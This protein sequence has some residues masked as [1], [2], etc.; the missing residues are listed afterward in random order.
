MEGVQALRATWAE[1]RA[2]AARE[3]ELRLAAWRGEL[4][5]ELGRQA[6]LLAEGL[7][8]QQ[9]RSE[10]GLE[11]RLQALDARV[12]ESLEAARGEAARASQ[13]LRVQQ[14]ALEAVLRSDVERLGAEVRELR[15]A[16]DGLGEGLGAVDGHWRASG[17]RRPRPGGPW[18]ERLLGELRPLCDARAGRA[19]LEELRGELAAARRELEARCRAQAEQA[20]EALEARLAA[21]ERRALE[22]RREWQLQADASS[23]AAEEQARDL[24][25]QVE[26]VAARGAAAEWRLTEVVGLR[27][28]HGG[29]AVLP[30]AGHGRAAAAPAR[31][32]CAGRGRRLSQPRRARRDPGPGMQGTCWGTSP[33]HLTDGK[34][35]DQLRTGSPLLG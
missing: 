6:A 26:E 10:A 3:Q 8:E 17:W 21:A 25:A 14:G 13:A 29:A 32:G 2:A 19:Q 16:A 9:R 1:H 18:E 15:A 4:A 28:A 23:R 22:G 31:A 12:R 30:A 34:A 24:R 35:A 33:D 5:E 11:G 27:A 20:R 7:L